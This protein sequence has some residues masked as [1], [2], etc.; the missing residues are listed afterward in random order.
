MYGIIV[1]LSEHGQS[2]LIVVDGRR[3]LAFGH[4]QVQQP[5]NFEVGDLVFAPGL[6][7]G[8]DE[9]DNG[10]ISVLPRFW[11]EITQVICTRDATQ[12]R[13][14]AHKS[15]S[16]DQVVIRLGA[17]NLTFLAKKPFRKNPTLGLPCDGQA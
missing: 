7:V 6:R 9:F 15:D 3:N 8:D 16:P 5:N 2:A 12:D 4:Y 10:I 17:T 1:W 11:P 13:H 14:L